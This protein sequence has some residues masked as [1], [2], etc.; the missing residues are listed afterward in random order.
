MKVIFLSFQVNT[1]VIGVKY[2]DA[3][4]RAEGHESHILLL[5]S[6]ISRDV[7]AALDHV[8]LQNPDVLCF[9]AMTYEYR[10]ARNF[11]QALRERLPDR[12]AVFGGIHATSDPES[13]L[14]VADVVVRGEGEETLVE[15]LRVWE[16]DGRAGL[17]CIAGIAFKRDG[18]VIRTVA[19]P[20][21]EDLDRLP[22][23]RH[24]P[25]SL[26]V[27]YRGE[28]RSVRE[29][30]IYKKY[31]R[32][33]GTFLSVV[34]SRGCPF[35]CHYCCHSVYRDLYGRT[36]IRR[37]KPELVLEE[38][39]QEVREFG[40]ILY[41]NFQD[42]CF[43][44]HP[45]DWISA[46]C[47]GYAKRVGIPF[48]VRTTPAHVTREKLLLLKKAG[49]RWVFAGLQTGSDR[50]NLEVYGRKVT[51][52]QFLDAA[53]IVADLGL[54][55]WYDV[56]LDNPYETECDHIETIEVLLRTPRPYQ[57][58]LFSL[59]FFPGSELRR[60]AIVDQIPVPEP[61]AKS[62]AQPEA[63]M[64]NRYIRMSP[65]L[66]RSLVRRLV[67]IRGNSLGKALGIVAYALSLV[68]EPFVYLWMVHKS[69]DFRFG[70][71]VRVFK[72]FY[73]TA[74]NDLLLRKQG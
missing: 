51:A 56:I 19:R 7:Q 16:V 63:T 12:L 30:E 57:L 29:P 66:P 34:S 40:N 73:I 26:Y 62:N 2:L 5:P 23:L 21:I 6:E 18:Q 49:L 3:V 43:M 50:I 33:Q 15:L 32:Y 31:A 8:V 70:R 1:D 58:D 39:E 72:A 4:I 45:L 52:E 37:R 17:G 41:V 28:I 14:E 55:A 11:A 47:E 20:F 67:A 27:A 36:A 46:F 54:S 9:S 35:S 22:P 65:T 68:M 71:T 61:G 25:K 24:L 38:I 42:D 59:D 74:F 60:R 64:M 69:N 13:C 48:L 44:T 10:R 53:R